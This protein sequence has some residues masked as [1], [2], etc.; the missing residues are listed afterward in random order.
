MFPLH[1][2]S[3]ITSLKSCIDAK[4]LTSDLWYN[5]SA[6]SH[7]H[8]EVERCTRKVVMRGTTTLNMQSVGP[9]GIETSERSVWRHDGLNV[10]RTEKKVRV[11]QSMCFLLMWCLQITDFG[12]TNLDYVR[13]RLKH[14]HHFSKT[15][16]MDI[17]ME[18]FMTSIWVQF[19]H[20]LTQTI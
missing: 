2:F 17:T 12:K 11:R 20:E 7:S 16:R 5:K 4:Y 9:F 13:V 14:Q 19:L 3:Y 8:V 6:G 10:F 15:L 1:I 18:K